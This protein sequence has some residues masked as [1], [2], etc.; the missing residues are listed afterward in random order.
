MSF[1]IF[2]REGSA[3][4]ELEH[5][6]KKK[7]YV[8]AKSGRKPKEKLVETGIAL[9]ALKIGASLIRPVIVGLVK[10]RLTVVAGQPRVRSK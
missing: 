5:R 8:D 9:G 10:N 2:D 6:W 3:S 4:C 7:I 1:G